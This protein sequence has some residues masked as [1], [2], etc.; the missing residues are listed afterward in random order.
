MQVAFSA[1]SGMALRDHAAQVVGELRRAWRD[2]I[3]AVTP[4]F[5]RRASELARVLE[6]RPKPAWQLWQVMNRSDALAVLENLPGPGVT[7]ALLAG[8]ARL[9]APEGTCERVRA[10]VRG[11]R[12]LVTEH[13]GDRQSLSMMLA[14]GTDGDAPDAE[15]SYRRQGFLCAS[16]LWGVQA[17]TQVMTSILHE[18]SGDGV[19]DAVA[20]RSLIDLRR[21]RSDRPWVI[22]RTGC[23]STKAQLKDGRYREPILDHN[24]P[25]RAPVLEEFSS[26]RELPVRVLPVTPTLV[27]L[28]LA[29]GPVGNSGLVTCTTAE[30]FRN[31]P[32]FKSAAQPTGLIGPLVLTPC[33][34]VIHDVIVHEGA[35]PVLPFRTRVYGD[36]RGEGFHPLHERNLL[37]IGAAMRPLGGGLECLETP[38]VSRYP[39]LVR[40]VYER[41]GWRPAGIEVYRLRLTYPVMPSTVLTEFDLPEG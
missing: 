18:G 9:G 16:Y 32:Q 25:A 37:P 19:V 20:I 34:V 7:E 22:V 35:R 21:L 15:E 29:E 39:E 33:R 10:A 31:L 27:D 14:Q 11:V 23:Y 2:V 30:V 5:P 17:R 8:A 13:A 12:E 26:P 36:A 24:N 6:V 1:R 41:L 38:D 28:E 40:H 4:R 3:G